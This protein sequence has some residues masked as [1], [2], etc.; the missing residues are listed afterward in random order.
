MGPQSCAGDPATPAEQHL[1]A[2]AVQR[3]GASADAGQHCFASGDQLSTNTGEPLF[4]HLVRTHHGI[5]KDVKSFILIPDLKDKSSM[6]AIKYL[7][8]V[9]V[10]T[11]GH[12]RFILFESLQTLFIFLKYCI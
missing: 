4:L 11:I 2:A 3:S 9:R 10:I 1:L 12:D 8:R 6:R 5:A 7:K